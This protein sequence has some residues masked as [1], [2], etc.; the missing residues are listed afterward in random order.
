MV[1]HSFAQ[2]VAALGGAVHLNSPV[3]SVEWDDTKKEFVIHVGQIG[4]EECIEFRADYCFSNIALPFLNNILS[5]KLQGLKKDQGFAT[6]FKE[7]LHVVYQSQF[8]PNKKPHKDSYV[9]RFLANT[10]KVGWQADRSLWQ[11]SPITASHEREYDA[12]MMS[13]PD[14]E[15]GV[16]PIFG[17]ISWTDNDIVQ[18]WYPSNGYHDE[19]GILTGAYNFAKT[20]F[21]WGKMSVK[22]RLKN[23]RDGAKLFGKEFGKGLHDGVAIAW[24]NMP[25]IKGGWAQWH[26][27]E[28]EAVTHFNVLGQGTGVYGADGNLSDPIF[29]II[30]DQ[31]SSL[32]GWQE[33]AIASALNALS[34]MA[35]PDLEIPHL[36][37]LPD[38]RLMVEGV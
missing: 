13:V 1:Q 31:M 21:A 7:S 14:S 9:P 16:V 37:S 35:R 38:T 8:E 6:D 4:T 28:E 27:L 22:D 33:G 17:G 26:V 29:F 2:K 19:K 10:T 30:G 20:A 34:R 23:A 12:E 5:E 18:I 3:K 25:Y 15:V 36:K 24:Q 11:G 32:P